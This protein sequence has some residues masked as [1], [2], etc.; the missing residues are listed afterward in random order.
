MN[1]DAVSLSS[2]T[3]LT[4]DETPLSVGLDENG[5]DKVQK[6]L[7]LEKRIAFLDQLILNLDM[8]IYLQFSVLY[9]MK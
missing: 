9:Y 7:Q 2:R 4:L 5:E 3:P 6:R 8:M 1:D